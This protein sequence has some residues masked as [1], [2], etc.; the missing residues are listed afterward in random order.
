MFSMYCFAAC[1]FSSVFG[2]GAVASVSVGGWGGS[3]AREDP[4][5]AMRPSQVPASLPGDV[6]A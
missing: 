1:A 5:L 2:L 6:I 4:A 3:E